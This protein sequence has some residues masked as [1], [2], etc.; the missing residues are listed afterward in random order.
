MREAVEQGQIVP[1]FS[2]DHRLPNWQRSPSGITCT[3][4][5]RPRHYWARRVHAS[6]HALNLEGRLIEAM[7]RKAQASAASAMVAAGVSL[8]INV[9]AGL[10]LSETFSDRLAKTLGRYWL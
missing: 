10:I 1:Y 3:L 6:H 4:A 2:A 9:S 8:S 7:C 5:K